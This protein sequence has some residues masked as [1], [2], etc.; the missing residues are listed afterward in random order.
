MTLSRKS[1]IAERKKFP[2]SVAALVDSGLF[3]CIEAYKLIERVLACR[4][5]I[6]PFVVAHTAAVGRAVYTLGAVA[7]AFECSHR[8]SGSLSCRSRNRGVLGDD[9]LPLRC[10]IGEGGDVRFPWFD[11]FGIQCR[12]LLGGVEVFVGETSEAMSE[13]MHYHWT[14][15]GIL[16]CGEGIAVVDSAAAIDR[17]V[18][19]NDDVFVWNATEFIVDC[20]YIGCCQISV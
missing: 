17:A 7:S 9:R 12:H 16:R 8:I 1:C 15:V 20:A 2:E 6:R 4:A 5:E 18:G 14:E 11:V 10:E 3:A 19:Q 13:F